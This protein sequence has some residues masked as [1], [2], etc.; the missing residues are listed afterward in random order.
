MLKRISTNISNFLN[1]WS[2][3]LAS[4]FISSE[5]QAKNWQVLL[6]SKTDGLEIFKRKSNKLESIGLL[7]LDSDPVQ[8]GIIQKK[9][10]KKQN[11]QN[12][13]LRLSKEHVLEKQIQLP[14]EAEDVI[15]PILKNQ[16]QKYVP[17]PEQDIRFG[18][19]FDKTTL[20]DSNKLDVTFY[21]TSQNVIET[22]LQIAEKINITP[23]QVEFADKPELSPGVLLVD[24]NQKKIEQMAGNIK[25]Y[26][27]SSA[28]ACICLTA[29]GSV[30]A[31]NASNQ[32]DS[33]NNDISKA[34][35]TINILQSSNKQA[36]KYYKQ[37]IRLVK[38]KQAEKP[39][40]IIIEKL[41][42]ALP[43][44]TYLNRL[45][46]DKK[47][48]LLFGKSDDAARLIN[49]IEQVKI[50]ENVRFSAPTIRDTEQE[51]EEFSISATVK[52]NE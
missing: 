16:M 21:A 24:H 29:L 19:E 47:N 39:A 38:K 14:K 41:S 44:D 28:L 2:H 32:K 52:I 13:V 33:L 1:W 48:V 4:I 46:I 15:E 43:D 49:L 20:S 34:R 11:P 9:L 40:L 35:K 8:F 5:R 45:E 18:Y 51:K 37:K 22:A 36:E 3:Q 26:I 7:S 50:F 42:A 10:N 30:L 31:F 27:I 25:R 17:W 23:Q 6:F 12:T